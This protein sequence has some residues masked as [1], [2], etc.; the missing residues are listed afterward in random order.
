M[1]VVLFVIDGKEFLQKDFVN[2]MQRCPFSTKTYSG[3]FMHEVFELY[4]REILTS[5]EKSNLKKK[6]P[7]FDL[8]MN[9]YR[10]GILLFEISNRKIWSKPAEEQKALEEAWIKELEKKYPVEINQKVLKRISKK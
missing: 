1:S 10:D 2:Y 8:L 6:H 7:E 4:V 5:V 9:E 3:D